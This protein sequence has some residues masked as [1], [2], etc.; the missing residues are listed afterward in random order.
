M[1]CFFFFFKQKNDLTNVNSLCWVWQ[2]AYQSVLTDIIRQ[3]QTG[4]A[5]APL[6]CFSS[7]PHSI[8]WYPEQ[9]FRF[10]CWIGNIHAPP[11]CWLFKSYR[12][13]SLFVLLCN[14][15][16]HFIASLL[17]LLSFYF[18]LFL[19]PSRR[20]NL[21]QTFLTW[22]H[23][24]NYLSVKVIEP[25]NVCPPT[26]LRLRLKTLNNVFFSSSLYDHCIV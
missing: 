5:F 4:Q 11:W 12:S 20:R 2:I 17:L 16:F 9:R 7:H 3:T 8:R 24:H 23:T 15:I 25:D 1:F 21:S 26:W 13:E 10:S 18:I 14:S 19:L 22:L 6:P